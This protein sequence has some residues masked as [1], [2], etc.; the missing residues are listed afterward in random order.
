MP[1]RPTLL[2]SAEPWGFGPSSKLFAILRSLSPAP[3]TVVAG[4]GSAAVFARLNADAVEQYIELDSPY[5]ILSLAADFDAVLTVMDPW[6]ALLGARRG[7]PVAYVDSLFWFWQW[8]QLDFSA[9]P[10]VARDWTTASL[11]D[12]REVTSR[13]VDWHMVSALACHWSTQVFAQQASCSRERAGLYPEDRVR[14]VGAIVATCPRAAADNYGAPLVSISGAVSHLTPQPVAGRYASVVR[15]I[16]D[17][18]GEPVAGATVTGNPSLLPLFRGGP[19]H[20]R[21]MGLDGFHHAAG[22]ASVLLAPAGLT[23]AV[24]AATLGTP[25]IFL[26]EQHGGHAANV[27][28]LAAGDPGAYEDILLER[29]FELTRT[30]PSEAIADLDECYRSLLSGQAESAL[31]DMVRSVSAAVVSMSDPGTRAC[32]LARQRENVL[33]VVG[34]FDGARTVADHVGDLL[35][36]DIT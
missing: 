30:G 6:A 15:Q 34:D 36:A 2:C 21:Q 3:R 32:K 26:P 23:T 12:L 13:P 5:E 35:S 17:R 22:A 4:S 29:W 11:D 8:G 16:L 14:V 19:W 1:R 27:Q 24:E 10:G 18:A 9:L 31:A 7:V 28:V 33:K 20:I 25:I